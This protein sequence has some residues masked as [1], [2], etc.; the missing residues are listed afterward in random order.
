MSKSKKEVISYD[1]MKIFTG[2]V[3]RKLPDMFM[4]KVI[5][6]EEMD[7]SQWDQLSQTCIRIGRDQGLLAAWD[8]VIKEDG[9]N[10][11]LITGRPYVGKTSMGLSLAKAISEKYNQLFD[12]RNCLGGRAVVLT[13]ELITKIFSHVEEFK[14]FII[15]IDEI[16]H[17]FNR[18]RATAQANVEANNFYDTIRKMGIHTI[19]TAPTRHGVD[20]NIVEEK[21]LWW[22]H[23]YFKDQEKKTV[24][25][26]VYF[27]ACSESGQTWDFVEVERLTFDWIDSKLYYKVTEQ[28]SIQ[29]IFNVDGL[30]DYKTSRKRIQKDAKESR[31]EEQIQLIMKTN[32]NR[33]KKAFKLLKLGLPVSGVVAHTHL[34]SG[35]VRKIKAMIQQ[36]K[37]LKD[38]DSKKKKIKGG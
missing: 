2:L 28:I 8:A 29:K 11:V 4:N 9:V 1:R 26:I 31:L 21:I 36:G 7:L 25:A 18:M 37:K 32:L 14:H 35:R 38:I 20:R 24:K 10:H 13:P 17:A 30:E 3:D 33:D 16:Q 5:L 27:N 23:C 19:S 12:E 22:I 34:G 6:D 15:F